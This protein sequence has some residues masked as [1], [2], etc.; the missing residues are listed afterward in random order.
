MR[1][2][3]ALGQAQEAAQRAAAELLSFK[4][5]LE[6]EPATPTSSATAVSAQSACGRD[7]R[8]VRAPAAQTIESRVQNLIQKLVELKTL[9]VARRGFV[10][11]AS[12]A[13]FEG[14]GPSSKPGARAACRPIARKSPRPRRRLCSSSPRMWSSGCA[15]TCCS[16]A[17]DRRLEPRARR[18]TVRLRALSVHRGG[19]S[20]TPGVLQPGHRRGT[21][22]EGV[23]LRGRRA[24]GA[25]A[26]GDARRPARSPRRGGSA[27]S[28]DRA[29]GKADYR[30][31]FRYDLK[32]LHADGGTR[33]TTGSPATSP[34]ARPR[35]PTTS[36]FW[37]RCTDS[38]AAG[39]STGARPAGSCCSTRRSE[40]WTS[41]ASPRRCTFAR[42]LELQ[43]VLA[44]PKERSEM[45]A[46]AVEREPPHP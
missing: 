28:Q 17:A 15:K 37:L 1:L 39:R 41:R 20:R 22:R 38:T 32:I 46:P 2:A 8:G 13:E 25:G 29:R 31:Y 27:G 26:A 11:S 18:R 16:C 40:R 36:R 14:F 43:L 6:P 9:Y 7:P 30:E 21:L 19:R 33:S 34:A 5:L 42:R 45:V 3:R 4:A 10:G 23:A 44:T 12:G 35:R 24:R